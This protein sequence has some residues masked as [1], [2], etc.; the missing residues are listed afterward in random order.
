VRFALRLQALHRDDDAL[1]DVRVG[2]H[3]GEVTERPAP[4]GSAKPTLVEGLAV[5]V[6][7]VTIPGLTEAL[8]ST[9]VETGAGT[10]LYMAPEVIE[11]ARPTTCSESSA[12]LSSATPASPAIR[13]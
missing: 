13:A 10:R 12:E 1:P 11:G 3:V 2:L 5:D 4:A 7:G 8:V 6:P 9:G